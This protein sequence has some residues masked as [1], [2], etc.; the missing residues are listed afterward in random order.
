VLCQHPTYYLDAW[1]IQN[2]L[3][4]AIKSEDPV[5]RIV[6]KG[7]HGKFDKYWK[8]CSL[9]LAKSVVMDPRFKMKMVDFSF[10]KM[11]GEDSPRYLKVVSDG[12]H[13]LYQEYVK[14]GEPNHA[15][16]ATENSLSNVNEKS[17]KDAPTVMGFEV[18]MSEIAVTQPARTEIEQYLKDPLV[19]CLPEF[20][21]LNW[22]KMYGAIYPTLSKM[23]RDVLSIPM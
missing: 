12:I 7:M 6:A 10:S 17:K 21:I 19:P 3:I 9:V 14:G 16:A 4:N 20:D 5:T 11:Y 8:D 22:W 2:E 23:A 15:G 13:K 18:F 1:K